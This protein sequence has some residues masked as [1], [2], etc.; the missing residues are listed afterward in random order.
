MRNH[1]ASPHS[2]DMN[3]DLMAADLVQFMTK[4]ALQSAHLI[5]HSMGGKIAMWFALQHPQAVKKLII[6]D[7]SPCVIRQS[8]D[9]ATIINALKALP[10]N[11]LT[12]RKQADDRLSTAITDPAN[13]QFLLQNLIFIDEQY[14]W[15]INLDY[16]QQNA[17]HIAGFPASDQH[18]VYQK[19]AL[20]LAGENSN[21]MDD[22]AVYALFPQA[23]ILEIKHAGHWLHVDAPQAFLK[24][25]LDCLNNADYCSSVQ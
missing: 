18:L 23:T 11:E 17:P 8:G 13:R 1:G 6:V 24:I 16:F 2:V 10:L 12:N 14:Q 7:I 4:H 22:K 5:G 25:V 3:Y 21:F 9:F 15:R 19:P 20:F